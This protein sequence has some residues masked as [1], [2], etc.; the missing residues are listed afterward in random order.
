MSSMGAAA[1]DLLFQRFENPKRPTTK[2]TL[3]SELVVRESCGVA[4]AK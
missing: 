1:I 2:L 3:Q 4:V